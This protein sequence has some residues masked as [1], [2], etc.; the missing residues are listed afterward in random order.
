MFYIIYQCTNKKG[1]GWHTVGRDV[2]NSILKSSSS[3]QSFL[4][5]EMSATRKRKMP[6]GCLKIR[7]SKKDNFKSCGLRLITHVMKEYKR[8]QNRLKALVN[9]ILH[10]IFFLGFI[11]EDH[12]I[13]EDVLPKTTENV[14][15]EFPEPFEKY[16]SHLPK[17]TPFS[18][19]LDIMDLKNDTTE[20]ILKKLCSLM[21][22]LKFPYPLNKPG[23]KTQHFYTLESTVICVCFNNHSPS[24]IHVGASLGCRKKA[25]SIMIYSSCINNTWHPYVS[26]AVMSFSHQTLES[27][28]LKFPGSMHCQAYL[29]DWEANKYEPIQPCK[30]CQ[31]LFNLPG[32]GTEQKHYPYGNCAETECLSKLLINDKR[33]EVNTVFNYTPDNMKMLQK[34]T[35]KKLREELDSITHLQGNEDLHRLL[36]FNPNS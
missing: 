25:K 35:K 14:K 10:S 18:I 22:D 23:N 27:D 33:M 19:L 5:G 6:L 29:R 20:K 30:N 12:N 8:E 3:R 9:E 17:R 1:W 13:P 31:C 26:Q 2:I 28:G 11:H 24:N 4:N 34:L 15:Q 32:K 36:V 16:S 7:E 21:E